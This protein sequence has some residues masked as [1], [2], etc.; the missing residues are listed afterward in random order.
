MNRR[1]A[2]DGL[3]STAAFRGSCPRA[4][5]PGLIGTGVDS[6]A[7]PVPRLDGKAAVLVQDGEQRRRAGRDRMGVT[8]LAMDIRMN[9]RAV[10]PTPMPL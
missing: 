6:I 7:Q 10:I 2:A 9:A 5:R 3:Q 4:H 1:G 8:T